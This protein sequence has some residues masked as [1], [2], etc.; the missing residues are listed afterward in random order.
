MSNKS[1]PTLIIGIAAVVIIAIVALLFGFT[2]VSTEE[3]EAANVEF[4]PALY[5]DGAWDNIRTTIKGGAVDL[6]AILREIEPDQEAVLLGH[7]VP[8]PGQE[9]DRLLGQQ[10]PDRRPEEQDQPRSVAEREIDRVVE[11]SQHPDE[12]E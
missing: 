4:D 3:E 12:V 6:A 11:I 2:V 8:D 7:L 9:V 5:V 1:R 10:V